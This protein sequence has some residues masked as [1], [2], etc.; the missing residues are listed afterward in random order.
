MSERAGK[1]VRMRERE[2]KYLLT[3][4]AASG[5]ETSNIGGRK[6]V[7]VKVIVHG[8]DLNMINFVFYEKNQLY[9][10]QPCNHDI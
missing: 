2:E 8:F 6:F 3:R 1:E 9:Y 4:Q 10:K 7:V 5:R